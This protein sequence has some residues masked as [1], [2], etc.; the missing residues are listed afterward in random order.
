VAL[1]LCKSDWQS[2][3]C[4]TLIKNYQWY[5]CRAHPHRLPTYIAAMP[6]H[7]HARIQVHG[8][9]NTKGLQQSMLINV[10]NQCY[11][12]SQPN[13][14]LQ[15]RHKGLGAPHTLSTHTRVYGRGTQEG[16]TSQNEPFLPW[17]LRYTP[18]ASAW[19]KALSSDWRSKSDLIWSLPLHTVE[20]TATM[21]MTVT[22]NAIQNLTAHL[23]KYRTQSLELPWQLSCASTSPTNIHR[24][25]ANSQ[26]C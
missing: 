24:C 21:M 12:S 18:W 11:Q 26:P 4:T 9:T 5:I 15:G 23:S 3:P 22:L 7:N 10:N 16:S 13:L 20:L 25:H 14:Q 2:I 8:N 17:W 1:S 19:P 6:I